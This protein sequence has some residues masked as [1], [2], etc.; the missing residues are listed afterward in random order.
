VLISLALGLGLALAVTWLLGAGA[1]QVTL[2]Q[3]GSGII[4]V[5]PTGEDVT[6]CGSAVSPCRTVQFAVDEALPGEEIR[7]ATGVYSDVHMRAG[8]TQVVYISKPVT[9]RGGYAA[10]DWATSDP[11]ANPTTLDAQGQ[12]RVVVVSDTTG[13]A[14][15][16]LGITGGDGERLGAGPQGYDAGGGVYA[17]NALSLTVRGC[18]VYSNSARTVENCCG[19]GGGL[20]LRSSDHAVLEDNTIRH[21]WGNQA[22]HGS[23][24]GLY[25]DRSHHVVLRNNAIHDNVATRSNGLGGGLYGTDCDYVVIDGNVFRGNFASVGADARGGGLSLEYAH[26]ARVTNNVIQ[27][28][29]AS[30]WNWGYGGGMYIDGGIDVRLEDNL[31]VG[32]ATSSNPASTGYAGGGLYLEWSDATLVN[33]VVADNWANT[34]GS[35]AYV[36]NRGPRF[37]H[38]T[39]ARN[40]GGDGSAFYVDSSGDNSS[41]VFLTNTIV[42]SHAVGVTV[43]AGNTATLNATLWHANTTKGG[44]A[45]TVNSVNDHLADPAFASDGYHLTG[46]SAAI[47]AGVE[48]GVDADIDGDPRPLRAGYDIGADEFL[49]R[50]YLPLVLRSLEGLVM[51]NR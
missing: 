5:V 43:T 12:G 37:L 35:G 44:G 42:F 1:R 19:Y 7:V 17:Y 8:I 34:R 29:V 28:N 3:S 39:L 51:G 25:V 13:V 45:G 50:I 24:G 33:T 49:Q 22:G 38:T 21:N 11:E 18:D 15:E 36:L 9:V 23:G 46:N 41:S 31:V 2:A 10:D 4:R 14:L 48:A 32:N 40:S 26:H 27:D 6:G 20:Y 30:K 47:D 16:G